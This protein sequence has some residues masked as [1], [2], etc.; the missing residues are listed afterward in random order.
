MMSDGIMNERG[1]VNNTTCSG[2]RNG[3]LIRVPGRIPPPQ[4]E[5]KSVGLPWGDRSTNWASQVYQAP[6]GR[7]GFCFRCVAED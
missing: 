7:V 5:L 4:P 1:G 2:S 6:P 3:Y